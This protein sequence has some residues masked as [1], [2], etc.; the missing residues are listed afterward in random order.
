MEP[1][2]EGFQVLATHASYRPER[3]VTLQ[4][5]IDLVGAAIRYARDN[6]IRMLLVDTTKLTGFESPTVTDRILLAERFA[7][8][9]MGTV[10]IALLAKRSF[11]HP[12]RI[13][14][15]AGRNRG[16]LSEVFDSESS[17][18]AWL[19]DPKAR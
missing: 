4:K 1:T 15:I 9:A 16:L 7:V 12:S 10:K 8:E 11:I 2:P 18:M 6:Q 13:G 3:E 19:L 17:A 5:A 14:I